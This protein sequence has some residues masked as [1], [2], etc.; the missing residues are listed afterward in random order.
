MTSAGRLLL[1]RVLEKG[2]KD[3]RASF[4]TR[5][6][7]RRSAKLLRSLDAWK[8][9]KA[10]EQVPG[11]PSADVPPQAQA[12]PAPVPERPRRPADPYVMAE[13][14]PTPPAE[15]WTP[16][17]D[18][19]GRQI[20]WQAPDL[21]TLLPLDATPEQNARATGAPVA[22]EA[23]SPAEAAAPVQPEGE[24]GS[25]EDAYAAAREAIRRAGMPWSRRAL[26]AGLAGVATLI[27]GTA[28]RSF[29]G[30]QPGF[31]DLETF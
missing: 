8:R 16:F 7:A 4:R 10:R 22:A 3:E 19:M 13:G 30:R 31:D 12:E 25:Y 26:L 27:N 18:E 28:Y 2:S 9:R 5:S 21:A 29:I 15:G 23:P 17:F 24:T 1:A 6:N 14:R 11:G 20:A